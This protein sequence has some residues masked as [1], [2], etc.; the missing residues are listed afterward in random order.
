MVMAQAASVVNVAKSRSRL[1][2]AVHL[3]LPLAFVGLV[4]YLAVAC[5]HMH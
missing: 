5:H 3:S 2:F 1:M 4:G